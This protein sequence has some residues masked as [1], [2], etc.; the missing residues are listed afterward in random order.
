MCKIEDKNSPFEDPT[1]FP[2][3]KPCPGRTLLFFRRENIHL[4]LDLLLPLGLGL[5]EPAHPVH[6]ADWPAA[7]A[8]GLGGCCA[9]AAVAEGV[10]AP[11]LH[12]SAALSG[13]PARGK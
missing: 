7:V 9:A 6:E 2:Y 12:T 13:R 1:A 4:V 11:Q 5:R 10:A 8:V 3:E